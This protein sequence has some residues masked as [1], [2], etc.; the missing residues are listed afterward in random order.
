MTDSKLTDEQIDHHRKAMREASA[1]DGKTFVEV[2]SAAEIAD[3]LDELAENRAA[4]KDSK[5]A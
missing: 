1:D 4:A 3:G 5:D 2:K